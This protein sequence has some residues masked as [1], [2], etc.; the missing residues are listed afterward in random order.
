MEKN[1]LHDFRSALRV[2]FLSRGVAALVAVLTS[3]SK[4]SS[5]PSVKPSSL[6]FNAGD[7]NISGRLRLHV[8]LGTPTLS[9]LSN[10]GLWA[11]SNC[12]STEKQ[13]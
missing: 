13:N 10:D 12:L 5:S 8:V 11:P 2:R 4:I 6:I 7:R 3:D 1:S 9:K